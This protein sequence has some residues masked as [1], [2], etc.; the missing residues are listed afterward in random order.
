M[1]V[2][3]ADWFFIEE[4]S[5]KLR[6]WNNS[7]N[8]IKIFWI[9]ILDYLEVKKS[10]HLYFEDIHFPKIDYNNIKEIVE[11]I[12]VSKVSLFKK[13]IIPFPMTFVN[14]TFTGDVQFW[15]YKFKNNITFKN[16]IFYY[17]IFE[18]S[19]FNKGLSVIDCHFEEHFNLCR[20]ES[21]EDIIIDN[22]TMNDKCS[23]DFHGL[24]R[25]EISFSNID[26]ITELDTFSNSNNCNV[27]FNNVIF[28]NLVKITMMQSS[29]SFNHCEFNN[30]FKIYSDNHSS[31]SFNQEEEQ[32]QDKYRSKINH[33]YCHLRI[34]LSV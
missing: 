27:H 6:N 5:T 33:I 26:F 17:L 22:M 4:D 30:E 1:H 10:F 9:E 28:N 21:K 7:E 20:V 29:F 15:Q 3:K 12:S 34:Q 23:F 2:P 25:S 19:T 13:E 18:S 14:C 8:N 16:S 24:F 31:L 11:E 32:K